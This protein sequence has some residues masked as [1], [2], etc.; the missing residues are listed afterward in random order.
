MTDAT[1]TANA[2]EEIVS[3]EVCRASFNIATTIDH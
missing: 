2:R 1:P 3:D